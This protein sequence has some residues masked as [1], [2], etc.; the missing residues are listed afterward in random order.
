M[1]DHEFREVDRTAGP[2]LD[3]EGDLAEVFGV[4]RLVGVR[5]GGLQRMVSGTRQGQAALFSRMA[6]HDPTVLAIA[7]AVLEHPSCKEARSSWIILI[8]TGARRIGYH[9]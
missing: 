7:G 4:D 3:G 9:L 8:G 2:G 6:Q 5:A 1:I